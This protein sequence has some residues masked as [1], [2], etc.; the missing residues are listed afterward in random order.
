METLFSREIVNTGRQ[1]ELDV[2][3]VV[4]IFEM[5]FM[6]LQEV[7]FSYAYNDRIFIHDSLGLVFACNALYLVGPFSF[8]FSM[9]CTIPFS[10]RNDARSNMRRGAGLFVVW[11][12]LNALRMIPLRDAVAFD[13]GRCL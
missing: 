7:V 6:H 3:K 11:I 12:L 4:T 8:L 5:I 9:G 10:R 1:T 2:L 13:Y